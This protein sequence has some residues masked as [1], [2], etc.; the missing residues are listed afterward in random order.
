MTS[1]S[2]CLCEQHGHPSLI[3]FLKDIK[4]HSSL[5]YFPDIRS[6]TKCFFL[7]QVLYS[8]V[9][10]PPVQWCESGICR[11]V[12]IPR[13]PLSAPQ[14]CPWVTPSAARSS[15]CCAAGP[16]SVSHVAVHACQCHS[17]SSSHPP[18]PLIYMPV[19]YICISIP[20][21]ET[22]SSVPFSRLH[23][24]VL[25]Y[26]ICFSFWLTSSCMRDTRSIHISSKSS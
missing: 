17:P 7:L 26:D 18:H 5:F 14:P 6:V 2:P 25:I 8:V 24:Y 15:L 23:R 13:G 4:S 1:S 12:P 11:C 22:S 9:L 21:L 3:Q 16:H 20:A 10:A 19:V